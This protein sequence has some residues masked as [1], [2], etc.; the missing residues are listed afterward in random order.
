MRY[1][2]DVIEDIR[3]GND[4]VEV[5]N[6]YTSLKQRGSS[7]VGLC[8]FHK[9]NT[10]SFSVSPDKQLYHCFGCGASGTVYNFIMD[11]ENY[12]FLDAITYLANRINYPLPEP[13]G[14]FDNSLTEKKQILYDIHKIV[15]KKFYENLSNPQ[16]QIAN[17]YLDKRGINRN[18]RIKFGLGYSLFKKDD[19][20]TFLKQKGYNDELI[21]ESGLVI[22][23]KNNLFFDRF[24]GRVMFPIIDVQGRIIGFGGRDLTSSKTSPKYLNSPDTLIFNKSYN[25]YSINIAKNNK[26]KELI[27]VEG[28][29]DVIALC[30]VGINN[31]VASLGT[32]FNENHIKLLKKY[33]NK[34]IT[35]FDSDDAG[36]KATLRAIPILV[37]NGINVRVAQVKDAK[38]PDEYISKFGANSFTQ[39]LNNAK[40]Y[41]SFQII[42]K[43]KDYNINDPIQKI[44]FTK[45]VSKI[46]SALSSPVERDVFINE[47]SQITKISKDAIYEEVNSILSHNNNTFKVT[48]KKPKKNINNNKLDEARQSILY[49]LATNINIYNIL[50]NYIT[51]DDFLD[52]VYIKLANLIFE[53]NEKNQPIYPAEITLKF[54]NTEEQQ[55]VSKVFMLKVDFSNS[56]NL[57]KVI[58]DQIKIIKKSYFNKIIS[59]N[60]NLEKVEKALKD[61]KTFDKLYINI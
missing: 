31:V 42:Q 52:D 30:Q 25:L 54:E 43:M 34:V 3:F 4:I 5:I 22:K 45:E 20:Y 11:I 37:E 46:I 13:N 10:P 14:S 8:P 19:I 7:Y 6:G 35:L 9:E 40:S 24:F 33:A 16:A 38:D 44:D 57:E 32:A 51:P 29:M 56:D 39:F 12:D 58:N 53:L 18:T 49:I 61:N 17:D 36:I 28:Y 15:A 50:K 41:I 1:S 59:E 27:L 23:T 2:D 47:A 55:K 26:N 48:N 60:K 21:L